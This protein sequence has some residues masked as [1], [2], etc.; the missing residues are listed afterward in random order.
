MTRQSIS[1]TA[2][3]TKWLK[4]KVGVEGEYAS[5]S[6]VVNDLIRK[7]RNQEAEIE[8]IRAKLMASEQSGF[9]DQ[10]RDEILTEFKDEARRDGKL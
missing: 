2:P 8:I 1:F 9:I 5:N 3:N 10:T 7:A 6:E 4:T